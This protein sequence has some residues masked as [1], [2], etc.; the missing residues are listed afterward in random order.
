MTDGAT[1]S[2]W[3]RQRWLAAIFLVFGGQIGLIFWLSDRAPITPRVPAFAPTFQPAP[4]S[5]AELIAIQNPT[6]FALPQ[7][8]SFSGLALAR[9][10]S[11]LHSILNRSFEWTSLPAWLTLTRAQ[12]D[13]SFDLLVQQHRPAFRHGLA[14]GAPELTLPIAEPLPGGP[15]RSQLRFAGA[16]AQRQL[17]A[18]PSLPGFAAADLLS[19]TVVRLAVSPEGLALSSVLSEKSGSS[20]ADAYAMNLARML[21]F[22]PKN[23]GALPSKEPELGATDWGTAVFEWAALPITSTNTPGASAP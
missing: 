17:L 13:A 7:P 1:A 14:L 15:Q 16:L 6:L 8:E 19:N 21:R 18:P 11:D 9:Q 2:G 12:L 5:Q 3:S 22:A 10:N 4:R 20:A 23:A